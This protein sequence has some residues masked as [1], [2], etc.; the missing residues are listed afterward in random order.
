M[1]NKFTSLLLT[2]TPSQ[3]SSLSKVLKLYIRDGVARNYFILGVHGRSLSRGNGVA[4]VGQ[5]GQLPT[6]TLDSDKIIVGSVVHA[7]ELN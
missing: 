2:M 5:S 1:T 6:V 4:K 7:P 3:R